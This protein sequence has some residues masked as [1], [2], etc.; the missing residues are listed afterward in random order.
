MRVHRKA[1]AS[2]GKPAQR[3]TYF[4]QTL[5]DPEGGAL[6]PRVRPQRRGSQDT[7]GRWC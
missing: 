6:D 1:V 5:A 2:R 3:I 4:C 7:D